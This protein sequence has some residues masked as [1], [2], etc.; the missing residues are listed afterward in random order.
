MYQK[1]MEKRGD[2]IWQD[3]GAKYHSSKMVKEWEESMLMKRMWWPAQSPD[4]NPIENVWHII[5]IAICK[6]CHRI[7]STVLPTSV[8]P[9]LNYMDFFRRFYLSAEDIDKPLTN[10][11][12]FLTHVHTERGLL[13]ERLPGNWVVTPAD[14]T[15]P[16]KGAFLP[17]SVTSC[18]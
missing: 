15:G 12:T 1:V 11:Q 2:A 9:S 7:D 3:D 4:L 16:R 18:S 13:V 17:P 14:A 5:K 8:F 10:R 6:R